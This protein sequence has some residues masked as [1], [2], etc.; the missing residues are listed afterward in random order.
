MPRSLALVFFYLIIR[1]TIG[2]QASNGKSLGLR[3]GTRLTNVQYLLMYLLPRLLKTAWILHSKLV[4]AMNRS[5]LTSAFFFLFS[6]CGRQRF[7]VALTIFES[8][9]LVT[10]IIQLCLTGSRSS[11]PL[12]VIFAIEGFGD[13]AQTLFKDA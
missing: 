2:V 10:G 11:I 9:H 3:N 12:H 4:N 13:H 7:H 1:Q 8:S 6:Q 5:Q